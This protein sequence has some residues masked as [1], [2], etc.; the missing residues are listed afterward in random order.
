M[1]TK[2]KKGI[3]ALCALSVMATLPVA[4]V[5]LNNAKAETIT[6]ESNGFYMEQGAAVRTASDELGIRFSATITK[7]YWQELQTTYGADATYKF[8]SVVTDGI[9]PITKNYDNV[10]PDF[11]V[12]DDY[13]F[14]STIVYTTE[15][16]EAAGLLD[17]ACELS[18]S[19]TTYVDIT[20][21]NETTATTLT[22]YGETGSRSMKAVANAAVL[23]GETDEDLAKYFTVGN[24]SEDKEGYV[25]GDNSGIPM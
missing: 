3:I 20:K 8:Y 18:L 24:R 25:F 2:T 17:E 7:D 12:G 4:V 16:L 5:S 11:T 10:K 9:K 21:A 22:A 15:E 19:A 6:A 23:A 14:Y 1:R 13:T